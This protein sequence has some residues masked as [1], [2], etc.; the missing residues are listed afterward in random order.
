M[1]D[2]IQTILNPEGGPVGFPRSAPRIVS[3]QHGTKELGFG[4]SEKMSPPQRS[5]HNEDRPNATQR[6]GEHCVSR[7]GPSDMVLT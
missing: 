2:V 4:H 3:L 1:G 7:S 5:Q 6:K